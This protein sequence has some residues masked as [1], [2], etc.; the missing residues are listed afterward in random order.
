[1][2][3]GHLSLHPPLPS[4]PL[5]CSPSLENF[6]PSIVLRQYTKY[7]W[8]PSLFLKSFKTVIVIII[9][10]LV[11]KHVHMKLMK[12]FFGNYLNVN[13]NCEVLSIRHTPC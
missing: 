5:T 6:I 13:D 1:M 2:E 7:S 11:I 4:H 9:F 8:Y 3:V 10:F 12:L